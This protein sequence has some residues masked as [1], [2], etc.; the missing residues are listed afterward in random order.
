MNILCTFC[1]FQCN[2][3]VFSY[4]CICTIFMPNNLLT[5]LSAYYVNIEKNQ[6]FGKSYYM[7]FFLEIRLKV[8]Y[9][10][11]SRVCEYP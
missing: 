10:Y 8:Y 7:D 6:I 4:S 5:M 11:E 1:S 3:C 2:I 9:G